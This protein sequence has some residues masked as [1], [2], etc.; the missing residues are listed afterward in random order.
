MARLRIITAELGEI[1]KQCAELFE[2]ITDLENQLNEYADELYENKLPITS[3]E[4]WLIELSENDLT[5]RN[6]LLTEELETF[7]I[8]LYAKKIQQLNEAIRTR[9]RLKKDVE[10]LNH[11]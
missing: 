4:V 2:E 3:F 5:K 7:L 10:K 11:G 6:L 8:Y 1:A 9:N